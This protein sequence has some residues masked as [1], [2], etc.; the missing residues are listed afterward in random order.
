[1]SSWSS[2]SMAASSWPPACSLSCVRLRH[3]RGSAPSE[4]LRIKMQLVSMFFSH[5]RCSTRRSAPHVAALRQS[6]ALVRP[7]A[8]GVGVLLAAEVLDTTLDVG[9]RRLR[10]S[11]DLVQVT[12]F[13]TELSISLWQ[14]GGVVVGARPSGPSRRSWAHAWKILR[15]SRNIGRAS[16]GSHCG[17]L[18]SATE[19]V[20]STTKWDGVG[21][22]RRACVGEEVDVAPPHAGVAHTTPERAQS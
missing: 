6:L 10:V 5:W 13:S 17:M 9:A 20:V 8:V 2:S 12:L 14:W 11:D 18:R 1:M 16:P 4:T 15:P 21:S 22:G 3:S 7:R 19:V